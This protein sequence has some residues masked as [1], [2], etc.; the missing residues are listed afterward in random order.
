MHKL[1]RREWV[2]SCRSLDSTRGEEAEGQLAADARTTYKQEDLQDNRIIS[3]V[4]SYC[5]VNK[6]NI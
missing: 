2:W 6:R 5:L 1:S 4:P 3:T